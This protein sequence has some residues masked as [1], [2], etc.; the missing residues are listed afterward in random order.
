MAVLRFAQ[1]SSALGAECQ[2]GLVKLLPPQLLD[3]LRPLILHIAG[4]RGSYG[5]PGE[6]GAMVDEAMW[7][8]AADPANPFP[9]SVQL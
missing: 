8:P 1:P 3:H 7:Q 9:V 4:A 2:A 5:A 6:P